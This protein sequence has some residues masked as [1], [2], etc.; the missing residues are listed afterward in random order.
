MKP[1]IPFA[2]LGSVGVAGVVVG[3]GPL[4]DHGPKTV[5]ASHSRAVGPVTVEASL[6]RTHLS[7]QQAGDTFARVALTGVASL[8]K[9]ERVPV[10]LTLVID[11]SGSMG[12]ERKMETAEDAGCKALQEL[13]PADRFSVVSFDNGA[14]VLV[15][16][17]VGNAESIANGCRRIEQLSARGSTDMHSGLDTGG[18]EAQ[19]IAGQSRVNRILLLSDGQP[20][21]EAGLAEQTKALAKLGITT[22]TIGLGT[23]YNEDLMARIADQ[24]MGNSWF[25]ESRTEQ[26][27]GSAQLAKIFQTELKSMAEVV[28]KNAAI[29]LTPKNGLEIVDVTG[30]TFD[31]SGNR[32]IIP[33]GDVYGGRTTDVLVKVRHAAQQEGVL[34][35]LDVDVA[36]VGAADSQNF[37]TTLAV[38]ATFTKDQ[39]Q[40]AASTV[41]DVAVKATEWETSTAMLHAN[42]AY[43]RGD[44]ASGD[45]I[46]VE[47]KQKVKEASKAFK[48]DKLGSLAA[49]V[50]AYQADNALGGMGTRASMNKK[51]KAMAR[52]VGRSTG[53]YEKKSD[54]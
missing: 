2:F 51:A 23:D 50:D 19:R 33:V 7:A 17:A 32:W 39:V 52:D 18:S 41:A 30:F 44:F 43:N 14:E 28:A 53:S 20:D 22:T 31:K 54:H 1:L 38:N 35:L 21:S 49:E 25:V 13:T 16:G 27:G 8:Q 15:S 36:F 24:G 12:S 11:R 34:D 47:Q 45:Q 6:A 29:T 3:T 9:Q 42:E 4:A 5:A 48:N 26:G 37:T 46:L 40:V 10:S